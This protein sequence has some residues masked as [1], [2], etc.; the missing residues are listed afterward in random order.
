MKRLAYI[1]VVISLVV[2]LVGVA[3]CAETTPAP[4]IERPAPQLQPSSPAPIPEQPTPPSQLPPPA[5]ESKPEPI[6]LKG[7]GDDVSPKFTIEEGIF[8]LGAKHDGTSNFAI[9]LLNEGGD[10]VDLL[11]NEIGAYDG[12][13][14]IGVRKDNIIGARPG[15]HVLDITADG[16][17]IIVMGHMEPTSDFTKQLP[18]TF[19]SKFDGTSQ[20]F[21]LQGG[22]AT[23]SMTHDGQS[24]FVVKLLADDGRLAELLVNEIG[25]YNG[26]KVI[27]VKKGNLIGARPGMHI[28]SVTADGNWSISVSQ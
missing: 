18:V 6:R 3:G 22:L 7:Q 14:A 28:L 26:K 13:M 8:I 12:S 19:Q 16:S 11:V 2:G 25:P 4:P 27:G 10:M 9:K 21:M 23:F 20:F 1:L 24:N 15:T 5:P 17:W